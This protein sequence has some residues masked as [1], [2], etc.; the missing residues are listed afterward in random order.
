MLKDKLTDFLGKGIPIPTLHELVKNTAPFLFEKTPDESTRFI[1]ILASPDSVKDAFGYFE[2]CVAA[3]F[4]TV[5]TFVPTDVDLA[6]RLKLWQ[7]ISTP[8]E[9][10]PMWNLVQEF[11]RWDETL[12]S[13]RRVYSPSG[14]KVSGHQGEWFSIAM[15]AYG[16]AVKKI[17]GFVPELR[18]AIEAKVKDHET[19][20]RE[21]REQFQSAPNIMNARLYLD[22]IAA[23]AHNLGDLDRMFDA[24]EIGEMDVLKR[25]VYRCGH[26]DARNP[27]AELL[28]AGNIYKE[29]LASENHRHFALREPKGIRKSERFLLNFGPFLDDWGANIV[30]ASTVLAQGDEAILNEGDLREVAEALISGWKRLN[31]K[32]IYTCQGYARA[33][34][35][36][37]TAFPN[38]REGFEAILSPKVKKEMNESGL[39]TLMGIGR[40]QFEKQWVAKLQRL[41]SVE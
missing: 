28:L 40:A 13:N 21:L 5:G 20:L 17:H 19:A 23:V 16:I 3:H 24:W 29:M 31:P 8:E 11:D 25:R 18:A 15:G 41:V 30:S 12:V 9:F 37:M 35:G 36:M 33:L 1:S 27:R 34:C 38:K 14:I 7:K 39:R 32:T 26:E 10:Q 22:A 4:S 2:Y 6:I